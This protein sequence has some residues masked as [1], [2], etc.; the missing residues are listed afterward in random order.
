[1]SEG[2]NCPGSGHMVDD[3]SCLCEGDPD[4]SLNKTIHTL[5]DA[6]KDYIVYLDDDFFVE[7][8]ARP[9]FEGT[10]SK[11]FG[12]IANRIAL[13]ETLSLTQLRACQI[14]PFRRLLAEG[15]AR[16]IGD[17]DRPTACETIDKAEAYVHSRGSENARSW[18]ILGALVAASVG[19][20]IAAILWFF[21]GKVIP[22][23][24]QTTFDVLL[25]ALLG[26]AGTFLSILNRSTRIA[27]DPAAGAFI[28]YL[29]SVARVLTGNAGALLV[30]LAVK[31]NVALGLTQS[32]DHSLAA[33]LVLCIV[34]GASER[35]V[36]G[37]IKHIEASG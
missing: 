19:L 33:L 14:L 34:A 10:Q 18:Y 4:P 20:F 31:A 23:L 9:G 25:G 1:M 22:E 36:P 30:A 5:I 37:L 13:L 32:F 35:L 29:E 7:W 26:G 27:M 8:S 17:K 28:H 15:M 3:F 24:D 6:D 2:A 12:E 21:R 16:I 11:D